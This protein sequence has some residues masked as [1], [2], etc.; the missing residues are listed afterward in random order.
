MRAL[1]MASQTRMDATSTPHLH[2]AARRTDVEASDRAVS[3]AAICDLIVDGG[4]RGGALLF[5]ILGLAHLAL[6]QFVLQMNDPV[7]VGMNFWPSAGLTLGALLLVPTRRWGWAIAAIAIAE[8]ISNMIHGHPA[9]VNVWFI[10]SNTIEP[11]VG[12][13]LIRRCGQHNGALVPVRGLLEL[14]LF[15]A[16]VAPIVGGGIG[17]VGSMNAGAVFLEAWPRFAIGDALG[18]LVVAPVLLTFRRGL[19][20]RPTSR[21]IAPTILTTAVAAFAI[22]SWPGGWD[23]VTPYLV[24]PPLIWA[25]LRSGVR[26]AAWSVFALGQV[27]NLAV[28]NGTEP[29]VATSDTGYTVTL[30]QAYIGIVASTT[31][32]L[33]SA[34]SE[35]KDR[36]AVE[37][38]LRH[39]ALHDPLTGLPNR[40]Y[41]STRLA[42]EFR[43]TAAGGAP[44]VLCVVDLDDFKRVNDTFGHPTGDE[45]LI[46]SARRLHESVR[47]T[48]L[49]ARVGGDEFVV[50]ISGIT[51]G[52]IEAVTTRIIERLAAPVTIHDRTVQTTVSIGVAFTTG[53]TD[54]DQAFRDA[55][56][57]MYLAKARGRNRVV[58]YEGEADR[59]AQA[60]G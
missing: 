53:D 60:G 55:D 23:T 6:A 29:F 32:I 10:G 5:A 27:A 30:L 17:S 28:A 38:E 11:L 13:A 58:H 15:G 25:A 42:E 2:R 26:G 56:A 20:D 59:D 45:L 41:F 4:H 54:P 1:R 24:I 49:V 3:V 21:A 9:D 14:V 39:Q 22:H 37:A 43:R 34:A 18:I 51:D 44:A 19:N 16:V 35:L 7:Q 31:L 33:A 46:A 48:D 57:A 12:A 8:G 40:L 36:E 47:E 52:T 50:V